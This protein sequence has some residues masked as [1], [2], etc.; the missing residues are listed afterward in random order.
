MFNIKQIISDKRTVLSVPNNMNNIEWDTR[1]KPIFAGYNENDEMGTF[2]FIQCVWVCCYCYSFSIK[3]AK[4][5][6]R[7][8]TVRGLS[9]QWTKKKKRKQCWAR[10][11]D[12]TTDSNEQ[13][14]L[15]LKR[16]GNALK[17]EMAHRN[18]YLLILF[19]HFFFIIDTPY[20]ASIHR[21]MY[22]QTISLFDLTMCW[23]DF[24]FSLSSIRPFSGNHPIKQ[25]HGKKRKTRAQYT[26]QTYTQKKNGRKST[27]TIIMSISI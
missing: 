24:F 14:E 20:W 9:F 11:F 26:Q 7:K 2:F 8:T 1:S 12:N 13:W 22:L 10:A 17:R 6:M 27:E 16:N 18:I 3:L 5:T 25:G 4:A 21:I 19:F 15:K 23:L